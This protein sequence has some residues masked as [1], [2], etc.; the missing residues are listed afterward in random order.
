MSQSGY[1]SVLME[2]NRLQVIPDQ[3][4]DGPGK[5]RVQ[6]HIRLVRRNAI[7]GDTQRA[8]TA[9]RHPTNIVL[10]VEGL[11]SRTFK[12]KGW[13]SVCRPSILE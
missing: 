5:R 9:D 4:V 3:A 13:T 11:R 7:P 6:R 1:V 8:A 12:N 10:T 2:I